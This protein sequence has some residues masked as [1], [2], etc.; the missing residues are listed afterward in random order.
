VPPRGLRGLLRTL[1]AQPPSD[2]AIP[3]S[4]ESL[5]I[6]SEEAINPFIFYDL[7]V[8]NL[9]SIDLPAD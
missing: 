6:A 5:P 2:Q 8:T 9:V 4:E 7:P 3:P 1:L